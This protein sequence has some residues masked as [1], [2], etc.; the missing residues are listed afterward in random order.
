M[1]FHL[2]VRFYVCRHN[3]DLIKDRLGSILAIRHQLTQM[4]RGPIAVEKLQR[5]VKHS[6]LGHFV[7]IC[8]C[9]REGERDGGRERWC[10]TLG[11]V[12]VFLCVWV[13][14]GD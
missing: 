5:G 9:E 8:M 2:L 11:E 12:C 3:T 4:Y 1:F 10:G 13:R 6:S 14:A 7:C